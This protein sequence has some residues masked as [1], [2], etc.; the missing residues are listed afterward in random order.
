VRM[1]HMKQRLLWG[2]RE[3]RG[4]VNELKL[5]PGGHRVPPGY[6]ESSA[7]LESD[8]F[9]ERCDRCGVR[10]T[11][12]MVLHR[13]RCMMNEPYPSRRARS[14]MPIMEDGEW[15]EA[16]KFA[17]SLDRCWT[18][19]VRCRRDTVL[20]H[21]TQCSMKLGIDE[22]KL[23]QSCARAMEKMWPIADRPLDPRQWVHDLI[24]FW[25][26]DIDP[27]MAKAWP[28]RGSTI[29]TAFHLVMDEMDRARAL[30]ASVSAPAMVL[31]ARKQTLAIGVPPQASCDMPSLRTSQGTPLE[32]FAEL[33]HRHGAAEGWLVVVKP[34]RGATRDDPLE[35]RVIVTPKGHHVIRL[36][37]PHELR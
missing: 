36:T 28:Y 2:K 19:G 10:V 25:R 34:R 13:E 18:C 12:P 35:E 16:Q 26:R 4:L 22:A 27:T 29:D 1:R 7:D 6:S 23:V 32:V 11:E 9:E 37:C 33:S 15:R 17:A 24:N 31:R 20:L 5:G 21:C 30:V 8:A 14:S 3:R